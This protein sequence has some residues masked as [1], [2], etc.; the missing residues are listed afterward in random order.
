MSLI[1]IIFVFAVFL[2]AFG[3]TLGSMALVDKWLGPKFW[4][5][6]HIKDYWK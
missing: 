4:P 5:K 6:Y 2:S 1:E 3:I